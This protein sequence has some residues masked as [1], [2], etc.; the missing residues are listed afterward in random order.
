MTQPARLPPTSTNSVCSTRLRGRVLLPSV[1]AGLVLA[2]ARVSYSARA[3]P[4][5]A[6]CRQQGGR[7]RFFG[8]ALLVVAM[9][10][11]CPASAQWSP[12]QPLSHAQSPSRL[13]YNFGWAIAVDGAG[14]V[15]ATWLE[16]PSVASTESGRGG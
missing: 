8:R 1:A 12:L 2:P 16:Q 5:K 3:D 14:V 6:H 9:L 11:P 4:T 15:H 7:M 10:A 13:R